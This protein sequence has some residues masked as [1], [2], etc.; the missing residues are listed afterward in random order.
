MAVISSY[1]IVLAVS[2]KCSAVVFRTK[3]NNFI[4][5]FTINICNIYHNHIHTHISYN[6]CFLV[7][8]YY[9][10]FSFAILSTNTIGMTNR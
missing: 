1:E 4:T 10:T 6:R 7:I 2:A 5:F 3:N 9:K 8:D